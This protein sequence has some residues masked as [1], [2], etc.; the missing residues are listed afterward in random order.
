MVI[1]KHFLRHFASVIPDEHELDDA[2]L[3]DLVKEDEA[4]EKKKAI[5][6]KELE[7][8]RKQK[9]ILDELD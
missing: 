7:D 9:E 6:Q 4:V 5:I 2:V 3:R 8:L 1:E